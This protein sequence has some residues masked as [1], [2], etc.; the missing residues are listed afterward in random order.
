M[1]CQTVLHV[2]LKPGRVP[3]VSGCGVMRES[4]YTV[5]GGPLWVALL[6]EKAWRAVHEPAA[7]KEIEGMMEKAYSC[8]IIK[9][10][11][12]PYRTPR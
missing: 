12:L 9:H 5:M 2:V 3:G 7:A 11:C 1:L 10:N 4:G 8:I 6:L